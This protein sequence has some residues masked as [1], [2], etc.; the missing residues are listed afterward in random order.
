LWPKP[1]PIHPQNGNGF[2]QK[3]KNGFIQKARWFHPESRSL[4]LW[5]DAER[6]QFLTAS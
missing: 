4:D 5:P 2:I 3:A 6:G 1:R